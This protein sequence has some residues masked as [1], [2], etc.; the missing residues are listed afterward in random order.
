MQKQQNGRCSIDFIY[1][2]GMRATQLKN[3]TGA[4]QVSVDDT[5]MHSMAGRNSAT[6]CGD[7]IGSQLMDGE[8]RRQHMDN[9][10]V[11]E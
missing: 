1:L 11:T 4:L 2:R 6:W 7:A 3:I 9:S 8:F 10:D 5:K